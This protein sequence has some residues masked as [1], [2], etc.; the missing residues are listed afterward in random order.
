M[1]SGS[2][3]GPRLVRFGAAGLVTTGATYLLYAGLL[4]AGL[5]YNLALVGEYTAGILLGFHLNRSWT[6]RDRRGLS[7]PLARYAAAYGVVFLLNALWLNALVGTGLHPLP[8]QAVA[9]GLAAGAAYLLQRNWVF[10]QRRTPAP[11]G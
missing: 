3:E 6:F 8:A 10:R 2:S 5:H 4:G 11:H 1:R 7:R 9:L